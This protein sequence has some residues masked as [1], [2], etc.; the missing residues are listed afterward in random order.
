MR[1]AGHACGWRLIAEFW[2]REGKEVKV[3]VRTG[4]RSPYCYVALM[5]GVDF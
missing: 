3:F 2:P 5:A 4:Q 1:A